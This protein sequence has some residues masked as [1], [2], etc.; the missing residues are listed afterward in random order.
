[1]AGPVGLGGEGD[2]R[3]RSD[4]SLAEKP[5]TRRDGNGSGWLTGDR[6]QTAV[7]SESVTQPAVDKAVRPILRVMFTAGLFDHPHTGAGG[8]LV[9]PKYAVTPLDGIKERAGPR[10]DIVYALGAAMEGEEAARPA[11]ELREEAVA[12]ARH[13]DAATVRAGYAP[14]PWIFPPAKTN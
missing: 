13:S 12:V 11:P 10:A 2:A 14:S 5:A 1:M 4:A 8:S 7:L 3:R 9:R 6:V